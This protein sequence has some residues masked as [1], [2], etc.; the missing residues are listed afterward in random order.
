MSGYLL[1][2]VGTVLLSSI[3]TAILPSGKTAG[4]IKGITKL[5]C[6][7]AIIAPIPK[8]L[9]TDSLF[10]MDSE[11]NTIETD[12]NLSQAVIQTDD[13]FIKY[14]CEMR[15]QNTEKILQ[16]EIEEKYSFSAEVDLFWQFEEENVYDTDTVMITKIIVKPKEKLSVE[17]KNTVK[18][19]LTKNYCKEV[20]IE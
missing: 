6:V 4:V 8:F 9:R 17:Q 19:Y 1:S 3:L 15:I 13:A 16:A 18:E 12:K 5:A 14:Y 11:K 20:L 7:I 2:I 10:D